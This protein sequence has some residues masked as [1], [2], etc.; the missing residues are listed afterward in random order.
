MF[1]HRNPDMVFDVIKKRDRCFCGCSAVVTCHDPSDID[2]GYCENCAKKRT[3]FVNQI[4]GVIPIGEE[5]SFEYSVL[6]AIENIRQSVFKERF[7]YM[8]DDYFGQHQDDDEFT[9]PYEDTSFNAKIYRE[10]YFMMKTFLYSISIVLQKEK[11]LSPSNKVK[12]AYSYYKSKLEAMSV[13]DDEILEELT[14]IAG[15]YS[16][17]LIKHLKKQSHYIF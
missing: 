4:T 3:D 10:K 16:L 6:S 1:V 15:G 7:Y 12:K 13:I 9:E 8:I 11:K 17:S 5:N 14:A 2:N